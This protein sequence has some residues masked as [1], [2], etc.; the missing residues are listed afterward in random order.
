[1]RNIVDDLSVLHSFGVKGV[2]RKAPTITL[3]RWHP[4]SPSWIKLNTDGLAKGNSGPAASGGSTD[5]SLEVPCPCWT[6]IGHDIPP[7]HF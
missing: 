5:T 2:P 7:T 1:M 6:R 4:P 3:V